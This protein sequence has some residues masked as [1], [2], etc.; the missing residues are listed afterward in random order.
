MVWEEYSPDGSVDWIW[1]VM[2]S[3]FT[4][5]LGWVRS[6][7]SELHDSEIDVD[8]DT[9]EE[10]EGMGQGA[11]GSDV[12]CKVS[13]SDDLAGCEFGMWMWMWM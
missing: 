10:V 11:R 12:G 1:M 9:G 5:G 8:T 3:P 7:P 4:Y 2:G 6:A 13:E